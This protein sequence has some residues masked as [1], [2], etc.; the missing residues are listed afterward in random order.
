MAALRE[1]EHHA[2]ALIIYSQIKAGFSA[3]ADL[4]ELYQRMRELGA[5]RASRECAII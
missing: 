1:A 5:P 2:H 4:R 3:G